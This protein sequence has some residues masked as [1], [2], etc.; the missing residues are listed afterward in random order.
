MKNINFNDVE[1]KFQKRLDGKSVKWFIFL[2]FKK[3]KDDIVI[4]NIEKAYPIF[5]VDF[6]KTLKNLFQIK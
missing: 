4:N 2:A 1:W 5:F 3:W 6:G